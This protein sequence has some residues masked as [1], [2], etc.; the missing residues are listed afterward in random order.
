MVL[1]GKDCP[2]QADANE[3]AEATLRCLR[4]TVPSAVPGVVFLSGGQSDVAATKRLN[5]ICGA[6]S[7]PWTLSFSFGRALQDPAMK[8]WAG[9]PAHTGIAQAALLHRAHCNSLAVQGRYSAQ[10]ECQST[11]DSNQ[12][13]KTPKSSPNGGPVRPAKKAAPGQSP[14]VSSPAEARR[15]SAGLRRGRESLESAPTTAQTDIRSSLI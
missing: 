13:M 15:V 6:G 9:A 2:Q 3:V 11:G 5:A 1:S 4:D 14:L 8:S 12:P 10:I 7:G